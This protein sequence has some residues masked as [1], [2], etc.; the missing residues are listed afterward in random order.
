M[1]IKL[2]VIGVA[3]PVVKVL[4]FYLKAKAY[5]T[6]RKDIKEY[7]IRPINYSID[8]LCLKRVDF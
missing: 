2:C 5:E 6:N 4:T 7:I 3:M 1:Q 8:M